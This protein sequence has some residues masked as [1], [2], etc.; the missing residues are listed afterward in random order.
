[1]ST[2]K[3]ATLALPSLSTAL[4]ESIVVNSASFLC[5]DCGSDDRVVA[6]TDAGID[7]CFGCAKDRSDALHAQ[8]ANAR[9]FLSMPDPAGTTRLDIIRQHL[10]GSTKEN[11]MTSTTV[12][13]SGMPDSSTTTVADQIEAVGIE[14]VA[15]SIIASDG[16]SVRDDDEDRQALVAL[17]ERF[18]MALPLTWAPATMDRILDRTGRTIWNPRRNA[19]DFDPIV[20]RAGVIVSG[21][22]EWRIPNPAHVGT[23]LLGDDW[24]S[25]DVVDVYIAGPNV[26]AVLTTVV[27]AN[28]KGFIV[29]TVTGVTRFESV[30]DAEAWLVDARRLVGRLFD[31][32]AHAEAA[33][34][35][36][37]DEDVDDNTQGF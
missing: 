7:L 24:R 23:V 32:T 5:V 25:H 15:Q 10:A 17:T 31:A 29:R 14:T 13:D 34:F 1:M 27:G 19:D 4:D 35:L 6:I 36:P 21:T 30:E 3:W 16:Q 33:G 28:A 8:V 11:A 26:N 18:D 2:S 37:D 12:Y 22:E 9:Q 20:K